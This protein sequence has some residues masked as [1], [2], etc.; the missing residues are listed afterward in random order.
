MPEPNNKEK[1]YNIDDLIKTHH[2]PTLATAPAKPEAKPVTGMFIDQSGRKMWRY[3]LG[4]ETVVLPKPIEAMTEQDFYSLPVSLYDSQPGR[5]PQNLTVKFKDP[6]WAGYWF[7]K[8]AGDGARVGVARALGY[9]PA[10]K[11]DIE[12]MGAGLNDLDGSV[13][14]HDLVLMKIHKA[15]LFLKYK[16]WIDKAKAMGGISGYK[17]AAIN[18]VQQGGGDMTKGN[19][20]HTP[21]ATEEFQGVG[22]VVNLPTVATT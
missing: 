2:V 13:E 10:T 8:K 7:N 3:D 14:Q 1:A 17:N 6:Q 16:E 20:Y 18:Y 21:Q 12:A 5:I 15:K 9:V 19:Y 4:G 22:P 11:D